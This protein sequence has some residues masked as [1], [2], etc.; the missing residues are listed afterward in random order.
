M[1]NLLVPTQEI[2]TV[3]TR[4]DPVSMP[5]NVGYQGRSEI[6]NE[7]GKLK[8]LAD[9][10]YKFMEY[11][12]KLRNDAD[13]TH[14]QNELK[15]R[16]NQELINFE[17]L[18]GK[19]AEDASKDT[20]QRLDDYN[21]QIQDETKDLSPIV[22]TSVENY[23]KQLSIDAGAKI[24]SHV[25]NENYKYNL[26]EKDRASK[27]FMNDAISG[28][29]T[30]AM[31][32]A[33]ANIDKT[34]SEQSALM[35]YDANSSHNKEAILDA[36]TYVHFTAIDDA[37]LDKK[38]GAA[39]AYLKQF[40]G[41]MRA[42]EYNDLRIKLRSVEESA[43][44]SARQAR[45]EE[46]IWKNYVSKNGLTAA[47]R[48]SLEAK[49]YAKLREQSPNTSEE[50][51]KRQARRNV[52]LLEQ[53]YI[54]E[55]SAYSARKNFI[56]DTLFQMQKQGVDLNN[57][58]DSELMQMVLS[59]DKGKENENKFIF[60]NMKQDQIYTI[61]RD[62]IN[63]GQ[64]DNDMAFSQ[65]KKIDPDAVNTIFNSEGGLD[66]IKFYQDYFKISP[67]QAH[68]LEIFYENKRK[69][70]SFNQA[71]SL[72][73]DL[74]T[75]LSYK[76]YPTD[77]TKRHLFEAFFDMKYGDKYFNQ[78]IENGNNGKL[79]FFS[80]QQKVISDR[81]DIKKEFANFQETLDDLSDFV[82]RN[83]NFDYDRLIQL[84]GEYYNKYGNYPEESDLESFI[85][86]KNNEY[87]YNN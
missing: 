23:A 15:E 87:I 76:L 60:S 19:D 71:F 78:I 70:K 72:K 30:K 57:F 41:D 47:E 21:N 86:D 81:S 31:V 75:N 7:T 48:S 55:G 11:Q 79:A 46:I 42:K 64:L 82:L 17:N 45:N 12:Q 27:L 5:Q 20:Q 77:K 59:F 29:G 24:Q 10:V 44:A 38:F 61:F 36:H 14:Y 9:S 37:I 51:L 62:Y 2:K 4:V 35:G 34:I 58:T 39:R 63:G 28:Y 65:A 53:S 18:H 56:E 6:N 66:K 80:I 49:E 32:E 74:T 84:V 50:E 8:T 40:K 25:L 13:I 22:K 33:L 85:Q 52:F 67:R 43:A 69:D 1:A 54:Q 68:E 16:H 83:H 73:N 26:E 3:S